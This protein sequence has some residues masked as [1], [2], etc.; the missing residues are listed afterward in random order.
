M[1]KKQIDILNALYIIKGLCV[2]NDR[3]DRCPLSLSG[4]C[5]VVYSTPDYWNIDTWEEIWR[6]SND[7]L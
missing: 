7:R 6:A 2:S 1:D 5:M 4:D 3:C